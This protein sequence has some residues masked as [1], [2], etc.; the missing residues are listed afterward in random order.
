MKTVCYFGSY[1]SDYS[2]NRIII[3]GLQQNEIK[4]LQCQVNG[5]IFIKFRKLN[6]LLKLNPAVSSVLVG[7]PGWWDLWIASVLGKIHHKKIIFDVF[8]P[9][10]E[11]YY[12]DRK[13]V[14]FGLIYYALDRI[15]MKLAN[16]VLAD[17]K[18]HL[19]LYSQEYG[20]NPQKGLVIYVGSDND[21]FIPQKI[22]ERTE[23]LFYGSYQ[24]LQGVEQILVAAAKLPNVKF[25]LI[26]QGQTFEKNKKFA[27]DKKLKNVQ[28]Q[29]WVSI[30]QLAKEINQAKIV[31]GIFGDSVKAE[32][33]IPNKVFDGIAS[34][35]AIITK[36]TAAAREL[37]KNGENALLVKDQA[38]LAK[39]IGL[40]LK[41]NK[42]RKRIALNGVKLYKKQL[43]PENIVK[44]LIKYL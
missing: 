6:K 30:T 11:T 27:E 8:T 1:D 16:L 28:F 24:P 38:E 44:E 7:F 42:L 5:T 41:D 15:N 2:R 36:D 19:H 21:I 13:Q 29:S 20:L 25:K 17:T 37:F 12:L 10:Y 32:S 23:V 33:V 18:T 14:K 40:L 4:V 35:K 26:G 31:L 3:K 34:A 22:K 39:A 9:L 43:E